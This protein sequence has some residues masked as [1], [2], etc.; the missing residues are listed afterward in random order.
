ML[1]LSQSWPKLSLLDIQILIGSDYGP[2]P[3]Y[4]VSFPTVSI[5]RRL[6][7]WLVDS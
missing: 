3:D 2:N 7:E 6:K 5:K 1:S 4:S